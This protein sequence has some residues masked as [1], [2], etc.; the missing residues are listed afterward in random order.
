MTNIL[1]QIS[2]ALVG[3]TNWTGVQFNTQEL[4][5]VATNHVLTV[6]YQGETNQF[7][8]KTAPS[9]KA[10]WRQHVAAWNNQYQTHLTNMWFPTFTPN[11]FSSEGKRDNPL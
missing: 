11:V 7:T 3:V 5:Y 2:V 9:D 8:L 4:G 6:V 1:A 10:V